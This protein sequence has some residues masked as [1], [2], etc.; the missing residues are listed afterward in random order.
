MVNFNDLKKELAN[1]KVFDAW[2]YV[3]SLLE[4]MNY[5]E[6]SRTLVKAV[7]DH[8]KNT[9]NDVNRNALEEAIAHPGQKVAITNADLNKA[10]I[11]IANV[12]IGS[13]L[14]LRKTVLE[15]FHY[16]RLSVDILS[17]IINA[18]LFGDDAMNVEVSN[19]PS[20][21][22]RELQRNA[23]FQGLFSI[24]DSALSDTEV[25][26]LMAFDNYVKHIKTILVAISNGMMFSQGND[27]FKI[28]PFIYRGTLYQD[29]DVISK[30]D[31]VENAV[32]DV[33][34]KSLS[35]LMVQLPNCQ[36]NTNRY[37]LL[38]FKQLFKETD[39]GHLH[40]QYISFFLEVE[41]GIADLNTNISIMPLLIKSDGEIYNFVFDFDT[42]FITL[43]GKGEE[44]ICGIA[45]AQPVTNSN[46]MYR[47]FTVKPATIFE[48]CEYI[49][50]FQQRY[51]H[52]HINYHALEGEIVSYKDTQAQKPAGDDAE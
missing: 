23:T 14:F 7:Y 28:K 51:S 4:T 20:K 27:V 26:Y 43:K 8:Q 46:E 44:G 10:N 39:G 16:A 37:Q 1:H 40:H 36:G 19:L 5:M 48:Y 35:E 15:F 2:Q 33:I 29:T 34:D 6:M 18:A 31:S 21:I 42:V 12:E 32:S 38:K 30:I 25:K 52:L 41:N 47:K 24:V 13:G 45:E 49:A 11:T 17:Q 3:E 50:N 9:L 22:S